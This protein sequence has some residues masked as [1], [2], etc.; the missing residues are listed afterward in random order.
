MTNVT[1]IVNRYSSKHHIILLYF[2]IIGAFCLF[3]PKNAFAAQ[4]V[5]TSL[6]DQNKYWYVTW[7]DYPETRWTP[8]NTDLG[9]RNSGNYFNGVWISQW[10]YGGWAIPGSSMLYGM[11]DKLQN[12]TS[13]VSLNESFPRPRF[14]GRVDADNTEYNCNRY[15]N[16][17]SAGD[18][19]LVR[20]EFNLT[21]EEYENISD[22]YINAMADDFVVVYLNGVRLV[23]GRS[24]GDP[25][26]TSSSL[27]TR[28]SAKEILRRGR[29][30]VAFQATNKSYWRKKGDPIPSPA[31]GATLYYRFVLNIN[32]AYEA[33]VKAVDEMGRPIT[34]V[35][36][37]SNH[38]DFNRTTEFTVNGSTLGG[39]PWDDV[40]IKPILSSY[41][42]VR[43]DPVVF[44]DIFGNVDSTRGRV[45]YNNAEPSLTFSTTK[46]NTK[47]YI[48]IVLRG[49][50]QFLSCSAIPI[51]GEAPLSVKFD[52][53]FG[54]FT[55]NRFSWDFGDG[56]NESSDR[57][58]AVHT[59]AKEGSYRPTVRA[60]GRSASCPEINV[61]I[62]A[63]G[64]Q[65]EI[66][67]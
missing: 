51:S 29:N 63:S 31:N 53:I 9:G 12:R 61:K 27:F 66:A 58:S 15:N 59:Y 17:V 25:V 41:E 39:N 4:I 35:E 18:T 28:L 36:I 37:E 49:D 57:S 54:G 5:R 52:A 60:A 44:R 20:N 45:S 16:C 8:D 3:M 22:F 43:F 34:G 56:K 64:P 13:Q 47:V 38:K 55:A 7:D 40:K 48:V 62:F 50:S 26:Y 6:T 14:W 33:N 11:P 19:L 21:D 46:P 23:Q 2:L 65:M 24:S 10:K 67:P 1:K 32:N 30:V 42:F